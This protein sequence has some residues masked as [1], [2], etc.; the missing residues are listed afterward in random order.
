MKFKKPELGIKFN[1]ETFE[2]DSNLLG[3]YRN[4]NKNKINNN[5][6]NKDY[7]IGHTNNIIGDN[8]NIV[9]NTNSNAQ[10]NS[11]K[12]GT[13]SLNL[14]YSNDE[15]FSKQKQ[16]KVNS[17][18]DEVLDENNSFLDNNLNNNSHLFMSLIEAQRDEMNKI[19]K[20]NVI[21]KAE[22]HSLKNKDKKCNCNISKEE[23]FQINYYKS[24]IY[25]LERYILQLKDYFEKSKNLI[26]EGL[27]KLGFDISTN[28][29]SIKLNED[30]NEI[31]KAI[32]RIPYIYSTENPI[33][34]K[35]Q[36]IFKNNNK[37]NEH[38]DENSV[39]ENDGISKIP[40]IK[41]EIN[42]DGKSQSNEMEIVNNSKELCF[43]VDKNTKFDNF[44]MKM[45]SKDIYSLN[46]N[47]NNKI[48]SENSVEKLSNIGEKT[49]QVN[50]GLEKI[51]TNN[52]K[53]KEKYNDKDIGNITSYSKHS[54]YSNF[55]KA[56]NGKNLNRISYNSSILENDEDDKMTN[57][58]SKMK[59]SSNTNNNTNDILS[60][61]TNKNL[62]YKDE[63]YNNNNHIQK[64]IVLDKR[65]IAKFDQKDQMYINSLIK[66][67]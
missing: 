42:K 36:K 59:I 32:N 12:V 49:N 23:E 30:L 22:I 29:V 55:S 45:F 66:N 39:Y 31:F 24:K 2:E 48:K 27:N 15:E 60:T 28:N 1:E 25:N 44:D 51:T 56:S 63:E 35:F 58:K 57:L 21:L 46:S 67:D 61:N 5:T 18:K 7:Q 6:N 40:T 53:D 37:E 54:N 4:K 8:K 41:Q 26:K 47:N 13:I 10:T 65:K 64:E 50:Q 11:N 14:N 16:V 43:N 38:I 3:I 17:T 62:V 33:K 52:E 34:K 9:L 19:S 20:E